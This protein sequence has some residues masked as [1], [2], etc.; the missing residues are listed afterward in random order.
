MVR[1]A[2]LTVA[3][4]L[5]TALFVPACESS[6]DSSAS[7]PSAACAEEPWDCSCESST[8]CPGD[9]VCTYGKCYEPGC[10]V[11]CWCGSFDCAEG[12]RYGYSCDDCD[13]DIFE[14]DIKPDMSQFPEDGGD[15]SATTGSSSR[16]G[17][18]TQTPHTHPTPGGPESDSEPPDLIK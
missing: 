9:W 1:P 13:E 11:D 4:F 16:C 3:L 5:L 15:T 7:G 10:H 18:G 8:D 14:P 12:D 6:S 17:G 2:L